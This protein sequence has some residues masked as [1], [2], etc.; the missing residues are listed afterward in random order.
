MSLDIGKNLFALVSTL[1]GMGRLVQT[2]AFD[3]PGLLN[4]V[5]VTMRTAETLSA[6]GGF[7]DLRRHGDLTAARALI[8]DDLIRHLGVIG[9]LPSVKE[10]LLALG[11][12]GVTHIGVAPP[13]DP[14]SG[15]AWRRLLRDLRE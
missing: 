5:R 2:G 8:P 1:P 15:N 12:F 6:G 11:Q 10:R 7:P 3:V 4:A 14:T 9:P 13:E